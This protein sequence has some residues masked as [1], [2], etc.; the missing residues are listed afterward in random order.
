VLSK[1]AVVASMRVAHKCR[2]T[3][4]EVIARLM[5]KMQQSRKDAHYLLQTRAAVLNNEQKEKFASWYPGC[6]IDDQRA[7]KL[8]AMAA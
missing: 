1:T 2:P 4:N 8:S 5:A 7:G 6:S 3:I